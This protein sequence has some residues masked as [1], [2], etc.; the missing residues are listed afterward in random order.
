MRVILKRKDGQAMVEFALVLPILI[1]LICGIIDFG[2]I[3]GNQIVVNNA[4][5]EAARFTAIH[6]NDSTSD[7]DAAVA[8]DIVE[9]KADILDTPNV[10][11]TQTGEDITVATQGTIPI[12]TPFTSIFL[13]NEYTMKAK[14]VMRIE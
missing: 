1:L 5:R 12:L 8:K 7:D 2:W 14:A 4:T 13:G 9:I 10:I 6:Y 11:V 3:F